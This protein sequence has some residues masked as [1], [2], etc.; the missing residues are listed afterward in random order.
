MLPAVD[1]EFLDLQIRS[2]MLEDS[3]KLVFLE[4]GKRT[5]LAHLVGHAIADPQALHIRWVVPLARF[6]G[7]G[8]KESG[9]DFSLTQQVEPI[10]GEVACLPGHGRVRGEVEGD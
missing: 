9:S 3:D 1:A 7:Q 6:R 4:E 2:P 5:A 8:Q 10:V